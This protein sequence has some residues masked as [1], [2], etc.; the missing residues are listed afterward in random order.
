MLNPLP[1]VHLFV[2]LTPAHWHPG[3]LMSALLHSDSRYRA[4]A[5]G[6]LS[7]YLVER[8]VPTDMRTRGAIYVLQKARI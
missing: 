1:M 8:E 5:L 3:R 6:S 4:L 2:C 7:K